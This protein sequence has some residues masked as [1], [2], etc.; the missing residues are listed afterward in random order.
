M[1]S[2]MT[3]NP[4][5]GSFSGSSDVALSAPSNNQL[6]GY[7]SGTGKWTNQS[8][9]ISAVTGLQTAL[10]LKIATSANLS[11]LTNPSVARTNLGLGTAATTNSAAYATAAQGLAADTA[12]QPNELGSPVLA[13][14]AGA[15]VPAGTTSGTIIVRYT[16]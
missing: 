16:A 9:A 8:P 12:V 11:D 14:P 15:A 10:D 4:N 13:L 6:I 5:A 3:F 1:V 2:S 7:N